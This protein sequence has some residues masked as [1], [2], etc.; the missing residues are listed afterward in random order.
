MLFPSLSS[1]D[2]DKN[3][4]ARS[5]ILNDF[6]NILD[7]IK[8]RR[9]GKRGVIV[10]GKAGSGKSL[11]L[12]LFRGL[13][14]TEGWKV[15][16][17]SIPLGG[18]IQGFA[19]KIVEELLAFF[20]PEDK[21]IRKVVSSLPQVP[22][23][24]PGLELS[25][26]EETVKNSFKAVKEF[27][28]ASRLNVIF[29][30]DCFER[31]ILKGYLGLPKFF[32]NLVE[33]LE[34]EKINVLF[35]F[36]LDERFLPYF[37]EKSFLMDRFSLVELPSLGVREA[38]ILIN[39]VTEGAN[40]SSL[41]DEVRKNI[42]FLTDRT[43]FSIIYTLASIADFVGD[44]SIEITM[45]KWQEMGGDDIF[46]KLMPAPLNALG[47]EE[48]KVLKFLAKIPVNISTLQEVEMNLAPNV[49]KEGLDGLK[50]KDIVVV[51]D[52][53]LQFASNALFELLHKR[54]E[55]DPIT[56]LYVYVDLVTAEIDKGWKASATLIRKISEMGQEIVEEGGESFRIYDLAV[57]IEK[58]AK[59]T[60]E[61]KFLHDA[62]SLFTLSGALY[63]AAGDI[64]RA[65]ITYDEASKAFIELDRPIFAKML[66][67]QASEFFTKI[68]TG[69]KGKSMAREAVYVLE[70]IA[71]DFSSQNMNAIASA[72]LYSALKLCVI[73]GDEE[74][75]KEILQK[76]LA[77]SSSL[78]RKK[79][80]FE[81][82]GKGE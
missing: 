36:A 2:S 7:G 63:T 31:F 52:G 51:E 11:L 1:F 6:R 22:L 78:E 45:E 62:F 46:K 64:E 76:A 32:S 29:L 56:M 68:G 60:L 69:W 73:A 58:L 43:P 82:L 65:G 25:E 54:E 37:G 39:R 20:P 61:K 66:L 74:R 5:E 17:F 23:I 44:P 57:K 3:F 53:F 72:Y 77:V 55:I 30:M 34:E 75:R 27:L 13:A 50:S 16:S 26:V 8:S 49:V 59:R 41:A 40:I 10:T 79:S 48:R 19:M 42:L 70:D 15:S 81:K 35:V 47:D 4:V 14:E 80:F 18:D 28:E 38:E 24:F 33:W 9:E 71:R 67:I 12:K 21:R